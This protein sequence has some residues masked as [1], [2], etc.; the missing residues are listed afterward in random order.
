MNN[1]YRLYIIVVY[2]LC[3]GSEGYCDENTKP[4]PH[5]KWITT[6]IHE[7]CDLISNSGRLS[8][9]IVYIFSNEQFELFQ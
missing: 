3:L 1:T 7:F 2:G 6:T 4:F 8:A 5:L 9:N